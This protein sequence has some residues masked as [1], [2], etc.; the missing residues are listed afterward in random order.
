VVTPA[1]I[2]HLVAHEPTLQETNW[3]EW[4]SSAD[5]AER[6]WQARLAK[7]ILGA[8]NRPPPTV[9]TVHRG[10]AF[11]LVGLQPGQV[12]GTRIVDSAV[13]STG[14]A[15]YLG[16]VGPSYK[17]D[18]VTVQTHAVAVITVL[19]TATGN[20]PYIARGSFSGDKHVLQD[21]R[22]YIRRTGLTEEATSSEV[23]DMLTELIGARIAAG[24][25]WPMQP[26]DA[27]RDGREV[28]VRVERGD[29]LVESAD[30][31]T[32]L[33]EMAR[34][35]PELPQQVPEA[36]RA[37]VDAAFDPLI[38]V[39]DTDPGR[40]VDDAW[41]PLREIT[42]EVY[43]FRFSLER[44]PLKVVDKVTVLANK[45]YVD[46]GWVDVAYPLYYWSI[47][48]ELLR[49]SLKPATAR[50][51]VFMAKALATALLLAIR[52]SSDGPA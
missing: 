12:V 24:P 50:T 11:F 37:R 40:A 1:D 45:G 26:V 48:E 30:L 14:L 47:D 25:R 22:I 51:Y 46:A 27:W 32:N 10:H 43:G 7:F 34:E 41:P 33:A 35:R 31:Y 23:D 19:P 4:K 9:R 6:E 20:R 29:K 5:L 39:A 44:G 38:P 42:D 36:I 52:G 17:L 8:A 21:G 16:T 2:A 49:V 3:L 13:V 15:R 28:Y 18:Y